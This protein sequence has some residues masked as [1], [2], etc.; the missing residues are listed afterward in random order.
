MRSQ[1][2]AGS[3]YKSR[4]ASCW[5]LLPSWLSILCPVCFTAEPKLQKPHSNLITPN[6]NL[7]PRPPLY[8]L[9]LPLRTNLKPQTRDL[10]LIRYQTTLKVETR[11]A[12]LLFHQTS[13]KLQIRN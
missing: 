3:R 1:L 8:L 4:P 5:R 11:D 7:P 9:R 10:K 6:S 13:S 2:A 12:K